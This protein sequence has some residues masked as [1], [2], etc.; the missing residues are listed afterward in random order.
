MPLPEILK[1]AISGPGYFAL[2]FGAVVGSGWVVVLGDWLQA[3]GP[4]GTALGF[5]VG[6]LTMA[7]VAVCYGE[8]SARFP[9]AGGEFL[10]TRAAFGPRLGFFVAWYLTLYAIATCAF[11]AVAFG[12]L[13]RALVPAVELPVVYGIASWPVT[14]DA[15]ILGVGAAAVIGSVHL[16][17]AKSAIGLQNI[18]TYGFIAVIGAVIIIGLLGG[19]RTNLQPFFPQS[20]VKSAAAGVFGIFGM[21]VFF[22]N[23]WQAALHAIEERRSDTSVSSAVSWM[24]GGILVATLFYVGIVIAASGAAPWRTLTGQEFP[25]AAAFRFIGGPVLAMVVIATALV[26]LLKTWMAIA[27]MASRLLVAQARDELLPRTLGHIDPRTGAPRNAILFTTI[28]TA[29][30]LCAGRA[31]LLPIVNMA[32]ICLALSVV[33]CL[34]ALVRLRGANAAGPAR[35]TLGAALVGALIC[36]TCMIGAAVLAPLLR[37][38]GGIPLEWLLLV[39]WGLLGILMWRYAMQRSRGRVLVS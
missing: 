4:G 35:A 8:L 5:I 11:E 2:A 33:I 31:A 39:A 37:S 21:S 25:A 20:S 24:V 27:W 22:L 28:S 29:V 16:R 3:A 17:G 15:L 32:A 18:V 7:V 1:P 14:G 19:Q 38:H 10:Y 34:V 30:G 23:G 12:V 6:G 26:S 9:T 36:G 13:A